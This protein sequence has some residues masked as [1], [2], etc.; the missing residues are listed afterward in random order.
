[1]I[2]GSGPAKKKPKKEEENPS[3]DEQ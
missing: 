3:Q 1:V 2:K